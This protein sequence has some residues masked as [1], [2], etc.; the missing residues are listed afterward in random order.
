MKYLVDSNWVIFV[1]KNK[2]G[3]GNKIKSLYAYGLAISSI[4]VAEVLTGI[5]GRAN[6]ERERAVFGEF[7]ALTQEIPF[8]S[9]VS[10]TFAKVRSKL[11]KKHFPLENFDIAI[12]A[13]AISYD[14]TLLTD[15][16]NHFER[17]EGLKV[18]KN[19]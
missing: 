13:T 17:I 6:E 5:V 12:A 1:L 7:L 19:S 16:K 10:E 3:Y 9:K 11:L 8:D 18:Y 4:S 15:N 2:G 14:L